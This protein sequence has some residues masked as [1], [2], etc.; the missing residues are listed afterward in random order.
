MIARAQQLGLY[1]P[2]SGNYGAKLGPNKS[3]YG[4]GVLDRI[5][6]E[7]GRRKA[8]REENL[9]SEEKEKLDRAIAEGRMRPMELSTEAD[10][11]GMSLP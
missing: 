7:R 4:E 5:K 8:V 6:A 11:R 10:G 9:K 1:K 2:Q 3:V